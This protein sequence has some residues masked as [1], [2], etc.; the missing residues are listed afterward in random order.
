VQLAIGQFTAGHVGLWAAHQV[1]PRYHHLVT[2]YTASCTTPAGV[3][4]VAELLLVVADPVGSGCSVARQCPLLRLRAIPPAARMSAALIGAALAT[5]LDRVDAGGLV[6]ILL[7]LHHGD[8]SAVLMS[9][10]GEQAVRFRR[11]PPDSVSHHER[12]WCGCVEADCLEVGY[13]QY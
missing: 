1:D 11:Q 6:F 10:Q 3:G 12:M 7:A 2:N 8:C 13:Y 5:L 4:L 9:V